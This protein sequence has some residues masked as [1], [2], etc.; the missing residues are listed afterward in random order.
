MRKQAPPRHPVNDVA[1]PQRR[2]LLQHACT[3]PLLCI[4]GVRSLV[5]AESGTPIVVSTSL[6]RVRGMRQ[7]GSCVFKGIQYAMTEQ[8]LAAPVAPQPWTDVRDAFAFGPRAWQAGGSRT[9]DMNESCQFLNVW[10]PAPDN[11]RRPVMVWLHGGGFMNGSANNEQYD[12]A[13]LNR[14]GDVI[15]V[16]LNH[17]LGA[18]GYL[19]LGDQEPASGCAG[20]LDLIAALRWVAENIAAF[21]G[22][23]ANVTIFGESGG[24]GKV[25]ALMAMPQ[26]KGLFHRAIVQSGALLRT[27]ITADEGRATAADIMKRMSMTP[28]QLLKAPPDRLLAAQAA[29]LASA[30]TPGSG[31]STAQ[32]P[33]S[34]VIDGRHLPEQPFDP[35][36]PAVS[37]EVP[38]LIGTNKD[39]TRLF[40]AGTPQLYSLAAD[41]LRERLQPLLK[42]DVDAVLAAYRTS[43][44]SAT[45]TDL[46]FA[47]TTA[48][49]YWYTSIRAAERKA[50]QG[51]APAY[52]YQF[53]YEGTQTAGNPPIQLK[54]AHATE[55]PFVFGHPRGDATGVVAEHERTLSKRMS[56]AWIAYA[57]TGD[58]NHSGL[59]RWPRYTAAQRDTMIFD[60]ECNVIADPHAQERVF[61][62]RLLG[63]APSTAV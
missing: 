27:A 3:L 46:Y 50:R 32:R 51:R 16:T 25:L 13:D 21:G 4:S 35:T 15:V 52:M 62:E 2:A 33:F 23:P 45:P 42:N 53:A 22:D 14:E 36:A 1:M 60:R 28:E 9:D 11:G 37:A 18:F 49:M 7:P 47:I 19:Y 55:I 40:F 48:Q 12:G 24:G 17:R 38:L 29:Y 43:R 44:P 63:K 20:M 5:A 8:R 41:E 10:T 39:E 54:A 30:G 31:G 34:P 57:R 61:W 26:A 6:G 58:P 59:P 56:R